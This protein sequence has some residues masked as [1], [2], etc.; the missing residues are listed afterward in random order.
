MYRTLKRDIERIKQNG[1]PFPYKIE[2]LNMNEDV[3]HE[4]L[5]PNT[6]VIYVHVE[7]LPDCCIGLNKSYTTKIFFAFPPDY[8]F[9]PPAIMVEGYDHELLLDGEEVNLCDYCPALDFGGLIMTAYC[10]IT[11]ALH[12]PRNAYIVENINNGPKAEGPRR[13]LPQQRLRLTRSL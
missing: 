13:T 5:Q 6:D 11:E 1:L 2:Y 4:D 12:D 7:I 3:V 10:I 8:P 9:K